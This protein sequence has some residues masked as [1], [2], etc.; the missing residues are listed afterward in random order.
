AQ[1]GA[2]DGKV[3]IGYV[4]AT[5][6]D[7]KAVT[8]PGD[9]GQIDCGDSKSDPGLGKL[10][11]DSMGIFGLS[12]QGSGASQSSLI[13][14]PTKSIAV[15]GS[16]ASDLRILK[17]SKSAGLLGKVVIGGDLD[18]TLQNDAKLTAEGSI[19]SI[20]I[21]GMIKASAIAETATL[22]ADDNI[23]KITVGVAPAKGA[24][25]PTG[26][27][28]LGV[29]TDS[30]KISADGFSKNALGRVTIY[31]SVQGGG[32][33]SAQIVAGS[34]SI[35]K[36]LITGDFVGGAGGDSAEMNADAILKSVTILGNLQGAGGSNSGSLIGVDGVGKIKVGGSLLGGSNSESGFIWGE[37]APIKSVEIDGSVTGGTGSFSGS[38]NGSSIGKVLI[39]G[40]VTSST[41]PHSANIIS[42][43]FLGSVN[44]L[45]QVTGTAAHNVVIMAQSAAKPSKTADVAIKSV[46][47][48]KDATYLDILAGYNGSNSGD[49]QP[50]VDG[51]ASIGAVTFGAGL[52]GVN[53][54]AG[55]NPSD[56]KFG[57]GNDFVPVAFA[58]KPIATIGKIVVTG[59]VD[60]TADATDSFAFT[61]Q[62]VKSAKI[63]GQKQALTKGASNDPSVPVS[64]DTIIQEVT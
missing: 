64:A 63:N 22:Q 10:T 43:T 17:I 56:G 51:N 27:V 53:I 2:G 3:N 25:A 37:G 46:K 60:A 42:D 48:G 20:V 41:G 9:L 50:L 21:K 19:G 55:V 44:I 47:I 29:G 7:L 28:V 34:A 14:G 39:K 8:I 13:T 36:V 18:G 1:A 57:N 35:G 62:L 6:R 54:A 58:G 38:I 5:G 23:G 15:A 31:G 16:F 26:I 11:L 30:A 32:D 40:D 33:N 24:P 49:F 4:N 52:S 12:T 45:G 59:T 61:A